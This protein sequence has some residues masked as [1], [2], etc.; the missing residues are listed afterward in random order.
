MDQRIINEYLQ[1]ASAEA[2]KVFGAHFSHE[3]DQDGVRFTVYA[4]SAQRVQLIGDFN[5]WQGYDMFREENGI[6]SIFARDI[7]PLSLYKYRIFTQDG[8]TYDRI[9][10]FAFYSEVRPNTASRV[11]GLDGYRWG[12]G[13]WMGRR[14]KNYNA[15][16]SIYEVH[17]GSWRVKSGDSRRFYRWT[18]LVDILIP[19]VKE[20]GYT[21]I[22]LL[23]ITE[24][25]LDAS[26]GYQSTGYFC[27]TS[28]YG[29]PHDLMYF[30]DRCHQE[31]IGVILDFVPVHFSCDFH[32]LHQY[33]GSFLYESEYEELR[34]SPWGTAL[35][36]FSKPHV[37]SFLKSSAD[38]WLSCFH[39][40]GIRYDAVSNLI[41][42]GG[43]PEKGLN[44][45]GI[46]FLKNTNF[47][48]QGRHPDVMLMAEDSSSFLKVTAPVAYGG[49]GFDYK[50]DLGWMHDTL[51]YMAL[52]PS[53]RAAAP[54]KFTHSSSYFYQDIFLLPLSHDEVVHGKKTIIGKIFG[55]YAQKFPQLRTLFLYMTAHPGK[56]LSFMGNELAEFQEWDEKKELGWNVLDY[57]EHKNFFYFI[58]QLNHLYQ[59]EPDLFQED[60]DARSF[61]WIDK[62][63]VQ[64]AVFA[65]Q[66]GSG[67]SLLFVVLN[68]SAKKISNYRLPVPKSG[69]YCE[70]INSDE[71][72]FGGS[73]IINSDL[74]V[75][76]TPRTGSH[77][78]LKLAPFSSCI[79]K[80]TPEKGRV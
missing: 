69:Q 2:W 27:P 49:L 41:Y 64:P 45:P 62:G 42:R 35:F 36:D 50:W 4:P 66:R 30:I 58:R 37:L 74:S 7:P 54:E 61:R 55:T 33:D 76:G 59:T 5:G 44:D 29:T 28:R 52:S 46:W 11:F 39:F 3:Y 71:T 12:D 80:Y 20:M 57:P 17:P 63:S 8:K 34:Y 24:H 60:Y 21:H 38:F 9:D 32:A 13:E 56:K 6:W 65:F 18:E 26:W 19:Y 14:G 25:P 72:Q 48:L 53:E 73:G 23:P 31:S 67:T 68:L 79:V 51:E 1:G 22:E 40:D 77:L 75:S 47:T 15:P 43:D 70:I 78:S 16:V 10:P